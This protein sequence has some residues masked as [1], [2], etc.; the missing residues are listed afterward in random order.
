MMDLIK[1][2]SI[3]LIKGLVLLVGIA[4]LIGG[5]V[6][7]ASIPLMF[8]AENTKTLLLIILVAAIIGLGLLIFL[9]IKQSFSQQ[10]K[11]LSW[12]SMG[13]FVAGSGLCELKGPL[14]Q[15]LLAGILLIAVAVALCGYLLIRWILVNKHKSPL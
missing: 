1:H 6:C 10:L 11:Y 14:P 4:M 5:G 3:T 2:L 9:I 15:S 7:S 13:L 12:L 8:F